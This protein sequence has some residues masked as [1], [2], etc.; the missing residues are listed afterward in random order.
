MKEAERRPLRVWT[1]SNGLSF[2]RL[3]LAAPVAAVARHPAGGRW[4]ILALCLVAYATDLTDGFIARRFGQ[5]SDFGRLIDPLADKIFIAAFAAALLLAGSLPLWYLA[6]VVG[7]DLIILAGGGYLKSRRGV[8]VQSNIAGK[9]A[10]VTVGVTLVLS[11]F[12]ESGGAVTAALALSCC[13]LGWSLFEYASRFLSLTRHS[14]PH[15]A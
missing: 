3:L 6:V 10:V 14:A 5:E 8:L 11:M 9:I 13:A 15:S 7:R 12:P 4:W 2:L 1:V